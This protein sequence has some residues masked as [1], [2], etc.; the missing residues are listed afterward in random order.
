MNDKRPLGSARTQQRTS[1]ASAFTTD[2]IASELGDL[3]PPLLPVHE[4]DAAAAPAEPA[5]PARKKPEAKAPKTNSTGAAAAPAPV[6]D[7]AP[8]PAKPAKREPQPSTI[9]TDGAV[10]KAELGVSISVPQSIATRLE[11]FRV[12]SG[13]SHPTI[14]FDAIESCYAQLPDLIRAASGQPAGAAEGAQTLFNRPAVARRRSDEPKS[15]FIIRVSRANKDVL[16]RLTAELGAPSR[17]ALC[18]AAYDAYL[19]KL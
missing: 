17:N 5:P 16:T 14:L 7:P 6:S 2:S 12:K 11:A 19:P 3:L 1:L 8:A 4:P 10:S 13:Q 9:G 18:T 15:S